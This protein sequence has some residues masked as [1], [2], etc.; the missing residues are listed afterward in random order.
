MCSQQILGGFDRIRML[1]LVEGHLALRPLPDQM[2]RE[3]SAARSIF[4]ST[5]VESGAHANRIATR[6]RFEPRRYRGDP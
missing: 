6:L 3:Y 1:L 5:L 4:T 2:R